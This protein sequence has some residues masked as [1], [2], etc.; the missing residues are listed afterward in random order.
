MWLDIHELINPGVRKPVS[1][2]DQQ[3]PRR[4][5]QAGGE[6]KGSWDENIE[7]PQGFDA[8]LDMTHHCR[9][10]EPHQQ[11]HTM[12][13]AAIAVA[14][15]MS[16]SR[17][18]FHHAAERRLFSDVTII[19]QDA[20]SGGEIRVWACGLLRLVLPD[21]HPRP[22]LGVELARVVLFPLV[23]P[24]GQCESLLERAV[25]PTEEVFGVV[26]RADGLAAQI[27]RAHV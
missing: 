27:G 5:A 7:E 4:C 3:F 17:R 10:P 22:R 18:D 2:C 21:R 6:M 9:Q 20:G 25:H 11:Q 1:H 26:T 8:V 23:V 13:A 15:A 12:D 14:A 16:R 19:H 24:G